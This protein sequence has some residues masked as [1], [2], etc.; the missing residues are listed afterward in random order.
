[1]VLGTAG[2][3]D[4]DLAGRIA[5]KQGRAEALRAAVAA[6]TRRIRASSRG[7]VRAQARLRRLQAD[8]AA[9]QAQLRAVEDALVRT[10]N[11]L[12][13][14]VNRQRAATDALREN[15]LQSYR[16]PRPDLVSVVITAH[17]FAD[18]L[19]KADFLKRIARQN[20]EVMDAARTSRVAV[21]AQTTRLAAMQA[22]ER[23][24]AVQIG[25]RRDSAQ[26]LE[27]A[28]LNERARNLAGRD[29]KRAALERVQGQ[30]AAL[31][32]RQAR[33][34]RAGI[35]TDAGGAVQA[36]A[37]APQAVALVMAAGNA[38]A[39]LPYLYGGGHGSFQANAYDC[40]GSVSYALAA[41][42]LVNS[43][44]ASGPFMSWGD[45]GPGQWITVYANAGHAF[46]VVAGWRFDTSALPGGGTRW[47]R[48]MRGTA[49]FVARHPP[50]L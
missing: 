40:S 1:M 32:K 10:R 27:N 48:A 47:T 43:P 49:G 7:L 18:L 33:S 23:S 20:A 34:A 45:P 4:A 35:R 2:P 29:F 11:R 3:A 38:I 46:M 13:R 31:R 12:T 14:L 26:A 9:Q 8:V 30:L 39:G 15:L 36:P 25:R 17:G 6:E 5:T 50:G 41:A 44:M 42:G 21:K 37:G 19:E 16:D 28:L 24:I 22:R